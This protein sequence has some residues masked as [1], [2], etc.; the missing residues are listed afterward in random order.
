MKFGHVD[1]SELVTLD[2]SLPEDHINNVK[3]LGTAGS[4]QPG[5]YV[6]CAKWGRDEWINLIYPEGT[7]SKDFLQNYVNHFN[8]IEVNATFYNARKSSIEKW[9]TIPSGD[10]KFCPKFPQRISHIKRLKEVEDFAGWFLDTVSVLDPYLG[11]PFLQMPDNF[12]PKYIDRLTGFIGATSKNRSYA[13]EVR[14]TDWF[15]DKATFNELC[16]CLEQND[17]S[18]IITDSAGRRDCI[19]QRLTTR[20]AFIRFIGYD[21]HETDY[22]RMDDWALR[23]KSW[24]ESGIENV[25]FFLHQ[26]NE[27]NTVH[28]A[29]YMVKQLNRTCNMELKSPIFIEDQ[30][31]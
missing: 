5:V 13:V 18:L 24:L 25:Y 20:S 2:L 12:T 17:I 7:K 29:A 23:I 8:G 9:A 1:K 3:I 11:L 16:S 14:H 15:T 27:I 19:H 6:G 4:Q 31:N 26:K 21:L 30:G 22:S 10:F 28:S